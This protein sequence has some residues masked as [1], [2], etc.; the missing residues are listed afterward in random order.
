MKKISV[1]RIDEAHAEDARLP[2]QPFQIWG[3]MIPGLELG[4][5]SYEVEKS[6]QIEEDCFPDEP[7]DVVNDNATFFGAYDGDVCIGVAVLRKHM[8]KYLYLDDLKVNR[9]YRRCGVG[10]ILIE[11]CM[12]EAEELGMQG[13]YTIGQA[14]NL[15]AC[16]FYL[17]QGFEIGGFDNRGYRGTSQEKS[18]DIF[19]YKDIENI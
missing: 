8:F 18:A 13:V 14:N 10:G 15:S 4:K 9:D 5:W 7:Y 19:F 2:N 11:A 12:H 16:L 1:R 17:K 6:E 3:R